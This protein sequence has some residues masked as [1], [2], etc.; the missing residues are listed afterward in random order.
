MVSGCVCCV[1]AVTHTLPHTPS[2][3]YAHSLSFSWS[4]VILRTGSSAHW[5]H[6]WRIVS[7]T[8]IDLYSFHYKSHRT[9]PWDFRFFFLFH[10]WTHKAPE[11]ST[12]LKYF[13]KSS[14]S[15]ISH[16]L[17]RS[18]GVKHSVFYTQCT[19]VSSMARKIICLYRRGG[20]IV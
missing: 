5:P 16:C 15:E 14:G 6:S 1:K 12:R 8:G 2:R 17:D 19:R 13:P 10:H 3:T 18:L 9:V 7:K 11:Q 4:D 20:R